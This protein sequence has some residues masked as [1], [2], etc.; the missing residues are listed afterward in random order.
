[1]TITHA[2]FFRLLP[3]VCENCCITRARKLIQSS[4]GSGTIEILLAPECSRML[5]SLELPVTE[6]TFCFDNVS[7]QDRESFLERFHRVYQKGGG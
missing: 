5:G 7:D 4:L 1:M 6:I 2:D 3:G